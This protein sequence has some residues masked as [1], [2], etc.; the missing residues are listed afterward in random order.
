MSLEMWL[1]FVVAATVILLIPGPTILFVVTQSLTHGR[2][3]T[4]P[5]VAGVGAGDLVCIALSLVGL[6]AIL[7]VSATLFTVLKMA[8]AL[9]LVWLGIGMLRK[10]R[11]IEDIPVAA[12]PSKHLF[13]RV[14]TVTALNPKGI[15]FNSAFMPQFVSPEGDTVTQLSILA[16]TFLLL[17]MLNALAYSLLAS[18]IAGWFSRSSRQRWLS[19]SGGLALIGAGAVTAATK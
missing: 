8:G 11:L 5:L 17:A 10:E 15:I 6:S 18:K 1:T 2:R 14:L 4:L 19:V 9:Y 13:S 7:A 3:A 12:P 16:A